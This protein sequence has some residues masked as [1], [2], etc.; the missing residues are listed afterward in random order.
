M[1]LDGSTSPIGTGDL[2][3]ELVDGWERIPPGY[4]HPSVAAVATDS[5]GRAYLLCRSAVPVMV[6]DRDGTFLAGWGQGEFTRENGPHGMYIDA[7]DVVYLVDES[8]HTIR[9][10][11]L[12]GKRL[13]QLGSGEQSDTGHT[14]MVGELPLVGLTHPGPPFNR[15]TNIMTHPDGSLYATDGYGNC[16]V[17]HF[18]SRGDLLDSWGEPGSGPGE[19]LLPHGLGI[20]PD[21]RLFVADRE[22]DR[23]Q[24]FSPEGAY[25]GQWTDVQRPC[26]VHIDN[27]LVYVAEMLRFAGDVT[28]AGRHIPENLPSRVS[29]FDV[30]GNL[31]LRWGGRDIAAPGNF[32]AAHSIWVDDEQ[33]IYVAEVSA[34][35]SPR[36]GLGPEAHTIQKFAR[37]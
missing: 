21:G 12:D 34:V 19:F 13:A 28:L 37:L 8:G 3:Y 36:T 10:Y 29:I 31:L 7:D 14:G 20:H 23:I 15:P 5:E 26:D 6:Y 2:R 30:E 4:A 18:E 32:I 16:R 25:L 9:T 17:H 24:I 33:S 35:M 1:T 22:N 27:G 11:T